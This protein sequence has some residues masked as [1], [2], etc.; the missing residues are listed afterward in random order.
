MI[1]TTDAPAGYSCCPESLYRSAE[2]RFSKENYRAEEGKED[3]ELHDG[4]LPKC[5]TVLLRTHIEELLSTISLCARLNA[6]LN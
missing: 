6:V 3:V 5:A 4:R 1:K 2:N